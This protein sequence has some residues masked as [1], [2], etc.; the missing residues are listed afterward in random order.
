[1]ITDESQAVCAVRLW[2]IHKNSNGL[3]KYIIDKCYG[4]AQQPENCTSTTTFMIAQ[5]L[6]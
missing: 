6:I 2:T 5:D 3:D 1:M 4:T